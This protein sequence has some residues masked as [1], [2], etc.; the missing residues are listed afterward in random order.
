MSDEPMTGSRR[1]SLRGKA[2]TLEPTVFYGKQGLSEPL[3]TE[4]NSALDQ[5]QLVKV[6]L[7]SDKSRR[8]EIARELAEQTNAELID[9]VGH[10]V[11]LYR[12][13]A[14]EPAG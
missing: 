11:V 6:R 4:L 3:L 10:V 2:Q 8:K 12:P 5:R 13:K 14:E 7:T 9:V 1:K